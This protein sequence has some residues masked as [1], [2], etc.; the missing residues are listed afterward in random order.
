MPYPTS[1]PVPPRYVEYNNWDPEAAAGFIFATKA[2]LVGGRVV[3]QFG[4]VVGGVTGG[5]VFRQPWWALRIGKS[6]AAPVCRKLVPPVIYTLA[7]ASTAIPP[8]NVSP[9]AG[10]PPPK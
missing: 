3:E 8:P 10:L 4:V 1:S 6:V 5:G 7:L 9:P 2:S